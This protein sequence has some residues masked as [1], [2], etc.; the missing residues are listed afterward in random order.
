MYHHDVSSFE[1]LYMYLNH[2]QAKK[3]LNNHVVGW[4]PPIVYIERGCI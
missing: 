3:V 4:K 1:K 2:M